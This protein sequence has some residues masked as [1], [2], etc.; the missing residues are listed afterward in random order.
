MG[1]AEALLRN[2]LKDLTT[3]LQAAKKVPKTPNDL[4]LYQGKKF[5]E[6]CRKLSD[7]H[8]AQKGGSM[9]GD[10]GWITVEDLSAMGGNL[11]EKFE[12]LTAGQWGDVC[13]SDQGV[14]LV[15]R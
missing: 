8:T 2:A 4:V 9:C 15:Q 6:L 10:L 12:S 1:E 13:S 14:H 11:R 3:D 5:A 7:C